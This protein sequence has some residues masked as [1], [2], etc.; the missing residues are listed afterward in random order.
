M[1]YLAW[2]PDCEHAAAVPIGAEEQA[3]A[4]S[5]AV[6]GASFFKGLKASVKVMHMSFPNS[7]TNIVT[8]ICPDGQHA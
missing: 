3:A 8:C 2:L 6:T 7:P 5:L 1:V 4:C